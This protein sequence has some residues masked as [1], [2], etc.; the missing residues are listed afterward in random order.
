MSS[1][2][3]ESRLLSLR[4]KAGNVRFDEA[5]LLDV[6]A[7]VVRLAEAVEDGDREFLLI[8]LDDLAADLWK[9]IEEGK[10]P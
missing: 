9:V 8:A 10:A 2:V 5:V 1:V 6:H 7:R 3:T 4:A